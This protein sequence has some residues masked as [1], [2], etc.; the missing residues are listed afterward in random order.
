LLSIGHGGGQ[1]SR[2]HGREDLARRHLLTECNLD[3]THRASGLKGYVFSIDRSNGPG[4]V[5]RFGHIAGLR[6]GRSV[7]H[8]SGASGRKRHSSTPGAQRHDHDGTDDQIAP[9]ATLM[10]TQF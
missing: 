6:D 1:A 5:D 7:V 10:G 3:G 4:Q 8:R 2:I 9:A